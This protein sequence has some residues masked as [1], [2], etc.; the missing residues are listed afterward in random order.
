MFLKWDYHS[1]KHYIH[2]SSLFLKYR[3][4]MF[5]GITSKSNIQKFTFYN[6]YNCFKTLKQVKLNVIF[7]SMKYAK[8]VSIYW[9]KSYYFETS[10]NV[11]K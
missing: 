4:S 9:A 8:Y 6:K 1:Y 3:S 5:L 2:T 7:I 11:S 10:I